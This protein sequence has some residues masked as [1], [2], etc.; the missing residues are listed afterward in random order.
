MKRIYISGPITGRD[1][2]MAKFTAAED[3]L[4]N[5]YEVINPA[6][7]NSLMPDTFTH[8]EYM[9]TSLAMLKCCDMIYMLK[10][11]ENSKGAKQELVYAAEHELPIILE[12]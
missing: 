7:I 4:K 1:D 9:T 10:G 11:W 8:E 12:N 2:Y 5:E 3:W 6:K